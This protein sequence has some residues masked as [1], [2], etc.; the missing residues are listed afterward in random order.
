MTYRPTTIERAYQLA[1]SGECRTVSEVKQRLSAEG[2]DR[3]ND[4]LYGST[5]TAAL[6]DRCQK[7]WK[8]AEERSDS[9]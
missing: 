1:E 8:P 4:Q 9:A 5:V 3:I 7:A 6:R 2:Y